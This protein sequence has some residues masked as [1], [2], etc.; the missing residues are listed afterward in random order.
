MQ[1]HE[2]AY[3]QRYVVATTPNPGYCTQSSAVLW[4]ARVAV[5]LH[6]ALQRYGNVPA[7]EK[8]GDSTRA[9]PKDALGMISHRSGLPT[10]KFN[11]IATRTGEQT[12]KINFHRYNSSYSGV[13]GYRPS[14][15]EKQV[16]SNA[17]APFAFRSHNGC[18]IAVKSRLKTKVVFVWLFD[19]QEAAWLFHGVVSTWGT[20]PDV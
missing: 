11:D 10:L 18:S 9:S 19:K 8:K 7:Q 5:T 2:G 12:T 3:K 13:V 4:Y 14:C 6:T 1:P 17:V 16:N 15:E 20:R